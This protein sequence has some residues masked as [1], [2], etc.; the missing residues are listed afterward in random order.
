[1]KKAS[2]KKQTGTKKQPAAK[3]KDVLPL[4]AQLRVA[5]GM[6][7]K[8]EQRQFNAIAESIILRSEK[9]LGALV[10][11]SPNTHCLFTCLQTCTESCKGGCQT[12]C[13]DSCL[14]MPG[15]MGSVGIVG[16]Q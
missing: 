3:R 1:M 4:W 15:C 12:N 7:T 2:K 9:K 11:C 8:E 6:A 13:E 5:Y 14:G 10:S 16:A